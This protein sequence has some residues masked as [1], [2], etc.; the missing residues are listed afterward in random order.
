[1]LPQVW[2]RRLS[3]KGACGI[4]SLY[5]LGREGGHVGWGRLPTHMCIG[6]PLAGVIFTAS[7][8][9]GAAI[10]FFARAVVFLV[11]GRFTAILRVAPVASSEKGGR[12]RLW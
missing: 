11:G 5:M 7:P 2:G 1:M 9:W 6:L 12:A 10:V 3:T 8:C 4:E